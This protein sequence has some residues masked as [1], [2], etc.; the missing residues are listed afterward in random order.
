MSNFEQTSLPYDM[1][2]AG[3]L[4]KH[5]MLAETLRH[6]LVFRQ[7]QPI[8]F[9]DLFGGEPFGSQSSGETVQRGQVSECALQDEQPDNRDGKYYGSGMLVRNLDAATLGDRRCLTTYPTRIT[10]R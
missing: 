4:L 1:G 2:S 8:R 5:G 10:G 7:K 9:L 6:R 3:D